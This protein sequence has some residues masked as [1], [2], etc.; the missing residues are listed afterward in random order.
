MTI[1]EIWEFAQRFRVFG[2]LTVL[3]WVIVLSVAL[4]GLAYIAYK[5]HSDISQH[6]TDDFA[7]LATEQ[8]ALLAQL[9][10]LLPQLLD[11][12]GT[13]DIDAELDRTRELAENVVVSLGQFRAPTRQ[14]INARL[15]YRQ[16]LEA[17]IGTT[18][19]IQREGVDGMAL[20]LHNSLQL[21]VNEA[22]D[23]LSAVED[24]QGG[25]WPQVFGTF[26]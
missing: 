8:E 12:G 18:H 20:P 3:R 10:D 14:I 19:R 4:F 6:V 11:G 26:F 25:A 21:A 23:F 2:V 15:E 22:G 17:V 24:F 13:V 1:R 5:E 9:T 16:S 7:A